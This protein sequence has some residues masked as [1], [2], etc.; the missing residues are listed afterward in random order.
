M[1]VNGEMITC[2]AIQQGFYLAALKVT[3]RKQM[4]AV[5]FAGQNIQVAT[6]LGDRVKALIATAK[7]VAQ[8]K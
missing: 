8:I 7:D 4:F 6:D 5:S 1:F 2:V 3:I